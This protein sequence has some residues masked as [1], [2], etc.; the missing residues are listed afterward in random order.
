MHSLYFLDTT[1]PFIPTFPSNFCLP[2][3]LVHLRSHPFSLSPLSYTMHYA[4]LPLHH[5]S[6]FALYVSVSM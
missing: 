3:L 5:T 4:F 1:P 2:S 6:H